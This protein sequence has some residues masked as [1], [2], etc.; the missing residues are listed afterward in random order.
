MYINISP[1][2]MII[3]IA[4]AVAAIAIYI[5]YSIIL[6]Q[7][8]SSKGDD[9]QISTKNILA[10]VEVLFEKQE[11]ALV[12]LL[13]TKYLDRVPGH[14]DVRIYLAKAFFEDKKYNQAIKQCSII[15]KQ[16]PSNTE[17][18][19]ILGKC[20]VKKQFLGKAIREYEYLYEQDKKN[21]EVIQTLAELYKSTEQLYMAIGA[22]EALV[23]LA[24]ND[25]EIADIQ[26]IIA[27]LNIDAH[28]YP[29]AFEAYKTRLGIYPK[30]IDT[31]KKLAELYVK[32]SNYPAAIETLL[33]MLDFVNDPKTLLWVYD[34]LV[35]MY[36]MTEDY[37]KAIEYSE[38]MLEVQGSDK[39]KIR[40]N[41]ADFNLKLGNV[42][43]G[44]LI[45]EDLVLMSQNAFDVT[46]E[47]A[48]AYIQN[49][50]YQKALDKYLLLLD[51]ALPRE[52]KK[53]NLYI[54]DMYIDWS[55]YMSENGKYEEAFEYLRSAAQYN[56]IEPEIFYNNAKI[57]LQLKNYTAAVD[58]INRAIEFDKEMKYNA[59]YLL[60]LANAH[61][62]LG[63][64]FEEK[65]ALTD[66]LKTD[67]K[68]AEG[69]Y[70]L[71][72]MYA[73]QHDI[74]NAEDAF[75]RAITY[76]P[77]LLPAKYNLALLYENNNR[78]R[79]RELYMEILAADPT[80]DEARRALNDLSTSDGF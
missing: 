80:Y 45:L 23:D 31:N 74:K 2:I 78:D 17:T 22:Y 62:N 59:K 43:E 33:Y 66:L 72:L 56:P 24:E 26:S 32:I 49:K 55:I 36:V 13:A 7:G 5:L 63:N 11:Y 41:I 4:F 48:K 39:F 76:D 28:D 35:T 54:A 46:V 53:V 3:V 20:Y 57:Y 9:L 69:L 75:K 77:E 1:D 15:L 40:D 44:I 18:H 12:E 29:A 38:K 60:V 73:A 27:Q 30:D 19:M 79:A 51:K 10:Q 70:R 67:D 16:K 8:G 21:K 6:Y 42:Q 61:H 65:K 50:E 14:V 37:T 52:A 68:N 71:G 58:S 47:L 64:F 25:A 34:T